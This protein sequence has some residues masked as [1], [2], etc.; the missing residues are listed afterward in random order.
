MVEKISLNSCIC[1]EIKNGSVI[2]KSVNKDSET[3][4]QVGFLSTI[5]KTISKT[6]ILELE[7]E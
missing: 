6:S 1:R 7:Y 3:T 4:K 5:S 2:N